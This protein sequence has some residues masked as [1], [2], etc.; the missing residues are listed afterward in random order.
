MSDNL[1]R[2]IVFYSDGTTPKKVESRKNGVLHGNGMPAQT[3]YNY[4][5]GISHQTWYENG[6]CKEICYY[7]KDGGYKS[8]EHF[9][10]GISKGIKHF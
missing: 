10:N 5:S 8:I 6:K 9:E 1:Q 4:P 2:S 7:D 3:F